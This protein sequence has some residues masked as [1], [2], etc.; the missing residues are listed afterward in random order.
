MPLPAAS[1][2]LGEQS[3]TGPPRVVIDT[4]AALDWLLFADPAA[5]A[6]GEAIVSGR[7]AW[8]GTPAM[9][10]E[11]A[12][13]LA[14]G[15][16]A[17]RSCEPV[18]ILARWQRH[19]A[20]QPAAAAAPWRCID[21]DDQPFLDLAVAAGARWLISRDKALL[22]LARRAQALGLAIVAPVHWTFA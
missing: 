15:L 3:L 8:V 10:E 16:A 14:G 7:L 22:K 5:R 13:V 19:C 12:R 2:A 18:P 9:Q 11:L 17:A 4:N 21:P 1:L 6:L 20:V